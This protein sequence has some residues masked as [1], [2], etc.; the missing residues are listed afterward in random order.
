MRC[1]VLALCAACSLGGTP[2]SY[3]YYVLGA[4]TATTSRPPSRTLAIADVTVPSYLDREQIARREGNRVVYSSRDRWAEPVDRALERTL[5]EDLSR[6]GIDVQARGAAPDLSVD[7]QRFEQTGSDR[8]ELW[9]RWTLRAANDVIDRGETRVS[10]AASA[11]DTAAMTSALSEAIARM[12]NE[13][14]ARVISRR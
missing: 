3:T 10:I 12:A 5:R 7:V 1:L 13:I 4:T 14:A 11:N 2:P 6:A 9:A 8:V